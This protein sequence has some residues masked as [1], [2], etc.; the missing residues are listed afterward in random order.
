MLSR[1][2]EMRR[3]ATTIEKKFTIAHGILLNQL[4]IG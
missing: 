1:C 3:R 2:G 4:A